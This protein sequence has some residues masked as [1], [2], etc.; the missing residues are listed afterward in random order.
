MTKMTSECEVN[1]E[2]WVLLAVQLVDAIAHFL[3][4]SMLTSINSLSCSLSA[5]F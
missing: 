3:N 5:S 2:L 1:L 4:K